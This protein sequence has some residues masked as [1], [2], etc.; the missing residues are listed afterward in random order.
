MMKN[1]KKIIEYVRWSLLHHST[2]SLD[3]RLELLLDILEAVPTY[4]A[5]PIID[6][7]C[8]IPE[9]DDAEL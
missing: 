1:E 4:A 9:E 3:T 8:R 5:D 2:A 7:A 6:A